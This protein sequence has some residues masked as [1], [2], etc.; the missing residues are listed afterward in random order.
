MRRVFI[1][2][3]KNGRDGDAR[4]AIQGCHKDERRRESMD[5]HRGAM[6]SRHTEQKEE[7]QYIVLCQPLYHL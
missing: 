4:A 3:A 6:A 7:A 1:W 5:G 2:A